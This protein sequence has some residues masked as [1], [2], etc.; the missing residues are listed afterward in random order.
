M[1]YALGC[2]KVFNE[3]DSLE[4]NNIELWKKLAELDKNF[5]YKYIV[6][7]KLRSKGWVLKNG[8]KYGSDF[9]K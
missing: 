8:I 2:L 9:R 6:Y 7:H 1:S 4:L 5:I 3:N